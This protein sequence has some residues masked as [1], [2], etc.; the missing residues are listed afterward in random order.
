MLYDPFRSRIP[1]LFLGGA[2][3]LPDIEDY[4]KEARL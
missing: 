2:A 4:L 1:H 3:H